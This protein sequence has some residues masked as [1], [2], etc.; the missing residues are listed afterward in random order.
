MAKFFHT[1]K[2]RQYNLKPRYWDPEQEERDT[3]NR[4]RNAELGIKEDGDFKP[5]ISKGEFR[6]GMTQSKWSAQSQRKKTNTRLLVLIALAVALA[7][8]MLR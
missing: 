2:P 1:P 3:R 7:W 4:R 5:L 8:Y 6:K